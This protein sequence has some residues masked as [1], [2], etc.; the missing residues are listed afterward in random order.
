MVAL[1]SLFSERFNLSNIHRILDIAC[2]FGEWVLETAHENPK[3]EVIGIDI[4]RLRIEFASAHAWTLGLNNASFRVMDI[5]KPLDFP[6]GLFD[7]VNAR[8]LFAFMPKA[9][10]PMLVQE[11][12]RITRSGGIICLTESEWGIT[13]SAAPENLAGLCMEALQLAGQSFSP[14]GRHVGITPML[15]RFL[16][17]AGCVNIQ[18]VA[19]AVDYSA[20]AEA[21]EGFY[22]SLKAGLKLMQPFLLKMGVTTQEEIDHLYQQALDEMKSKDFC[23]LLYLLS[24]WG[25]KP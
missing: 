16:R 8:L 6:D 20:G 25:E 24:A 23:A 1:S 2:G 9:S 5:L 21:Y 7:L 11:C 10:W 12:F 17:D 3:I 15:G 4:D 22:E 14:D 13:N 19:H 18:K